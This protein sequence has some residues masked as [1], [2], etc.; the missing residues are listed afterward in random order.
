MGR[1]DRGLKRADRGVVRALIGRIGAGRIED[2]PDR[3]APCVISA[4]EC[5]MCH[6]RADHGYATV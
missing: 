1:A 3:S 5:D 4:Y 6:L 2:G